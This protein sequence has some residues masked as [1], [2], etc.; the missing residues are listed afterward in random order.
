M[1][2]RRH[3]AAASRRNF[4]KGAS[5]VGAAAAITAPEAAKA[6]PGAPQ[7]RLKAAIPG[8]LQTA[9]ET[10]P[11]ANDPVNQTSSGGDF[12]ID[13]LNSLGIKYLAINC[14]SSYRGLHEAAVNH[15][16]NKPE[17]ITCV[18]EDIAVHMAQ[19]YA[20]MESK[21]MAMACHG[22]VGLQHAA[23]AIYNA[24]CDRVPVFVMG[25]NIMEADKRAPGAEWPHSGVDIGQLVREFTK[26]DDQPASLQHFAESAMR[27]YKIATTPPMGPVF[28]ALDA[29]LQENPIADGKNL[30]IPRFERVIP[31]QGDSGAIAEA[32]KLLVEA[33]NPLIICD[34]M[35]RTPAGMANLVVL[36]ETLQCGVIDNVGR[37]NFPSRHPLNQ[38]FRRGL[39]AQA[40]VILA[41]EM[42]DLWGTLTHFS[43]RIV[44]QSRSNTKS[45]A[46][47]ITLGVRD[48]Y[49]KSNYQDF[50][51]WQD[52]DLNIAG[53]G[54]ASLP[55]LTEAVRRLID[56]GRKSAFEAR[57]QKLAKLHMA[58]VEQSKT[59]ATVG[60]DASPITTARMCAEVYNQ[61]KDQ[62]W[63]LVGTA[64]RLTWPHRLWDFKKPQQW[65]GVSGG[66]GV[67]YNLPASLG[68][69]LANKKHGRFT[70][71]FG[72]DGDF[73]FNPGALWT[74]AHH[75]IPLLYVVH[76]NRAYHQEYM[77]LTA[78]AAR[79]GRGV[80]RMDIGTTLKDPNI[81][82][83]TIAR[84]MGAHGEGP[85]TDPKELAPALARAV[86][87]V[88]SGEPAVVD[89]VTDPR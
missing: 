43:D 78:M 57:G 84:G 79:H 6:I 51:R 77:Y 16:N 86:A 25:G 46:K 60:W 11:P 19:G 85:I 13:V 48:L 10:M 23:M 41:I 32:A 30:R 88:K 24:W 9:A 4:L 38:S 56:D 37:M 53:D 26:W 82:Y 17:I 63:S 47:L 22:V 59:D 54:E 21:P 42:N 66:G 5:L 70:V 31:P 1:P 67:G 68:A 62:D 34:R 61:I 27:A 40:D 81:D 58:M 80:E 2:K 69:A 49:L 71:A 39:I 74:A 35:A 3:S 29:E 33:Q 89:V 15:G 12:M 55:V 28:L 65:N 36:A 50:G 8:P 87:V 75:K 73:M 44:R 83:A 45:G 52:V 76:N 14:A 7:E 64:I 18:H 20:K 72:G